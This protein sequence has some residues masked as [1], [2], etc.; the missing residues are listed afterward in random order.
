LVVGILFSVHV[1]PLSVDCAFL[2][3]LNATANRSVLGTT[4][5]NVGVGVIVGVILVVGVMDGVIDD[6]IDGVIVGDTDTVI[7]GVID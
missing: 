5:D 1:F 2:L 3:E 6:V 7:D 4:L